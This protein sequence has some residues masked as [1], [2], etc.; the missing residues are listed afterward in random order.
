MKLV[1]DRPN[2]MNDPIIEDENTA[3]GPE[4]DA[5]GQAALLLAESI[6]HALV[7]TNTLSADQALSVID[8]TCEV[9]VEVA[10]RTN[11]C[12]CFAAYPVALKQI[13]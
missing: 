1:F 6:L 3:A 9:K 11:R 8:T 12:L 2:E 4:P 5:H 10:E 13:G 7:E